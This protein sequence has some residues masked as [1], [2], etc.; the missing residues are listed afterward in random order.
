MT[1]H[2]AQVLIGLVDGYGLLG[3]LLLMA[4][5]SC[6]VPVPSEFVMPPAGALAAAGHL[7][8][9]AT[10]LAGA[11]GNLIGSLVAYG[12]A[13]RFGRRL[14]LGPGAWVGISRRHLESAEGWFR[15]YGAAAVFFGRMLPVV[16]TYI[17]FPAGLAR[18]PLVRFCALTFL[19]SLPW[20]AALAAAGY[21][22]GSHYREIASVYEPV[23]VAFGVALVL[24]VAAWLGRNRRRGRGERP[25]R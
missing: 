19:G 4:V 25:P 12:L 20:S 18:V 11:L 2:V 1:A 7:S 16:R 6:G 22:L 9:P 13:A 3:I 24:L 10:I 21:A 23:S 15:R 5:E 17:S 8:L 14:L